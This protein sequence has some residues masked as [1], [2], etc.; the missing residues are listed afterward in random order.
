MTAEDN[1]P[2]LLIVNKAALKEE[3]KVTIE[4][5]ESTAND[6]NVPYIETSAKMKTNVEKAFFDVMRMI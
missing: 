2:F 3:K 5:A 6:W 1:M 4:E